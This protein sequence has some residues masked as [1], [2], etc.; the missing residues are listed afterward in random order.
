MTKVDATK[1]TFENQE[2]SIKEI[3]S[4]LGGNFFGRTI[5]RIILK[6]RKGIWVN[7]QKVA[8][9]LKSL[10]VETLDNIYQASKTNYLKTL[11]VN[12]QRFKLA[13]LQNKKVEVL[14][15]LDTDSKF[16][17]Q[18]E[19]YAK[20]IGRLAGLIDPQAKLFH[21]SEVN[22]KFI[23]HARDLLDSNFRGK[24]D[25]YLKLI[26]HLVHLSDIP[27]GTAL[28]IH[29]N[30]LVWVRKDSEEWKIIPPYSESKISVN[31]SELEFVDLDTVNLEILEEDFAVIIDGKKFSSPEHALNNEELSRA[32]EEFK[33]KL[34]ELA[35]G[36]QFQFKVDSS[37]PF[38]T[39]DEGL[40]EAE[41][42]TNF[43]SNKDERFIQEQSHDDLESVAILQAKGYLPEGEFCADWVAIDTI[44]DMTIAIVADAAKNNQNSHEGSMELTNRFR[45][46]LIS[47][48]IKL[49]KD[50]NL[51]TEDVTEALTQAIIRAEFATR[52][53]A[54][55]IASTMACTI[56]IPSEEKKYAIGFCLGDARVML[57]REDGTGKDLSPTEFFSSYSF[58]GANFGA[59]IRKIQPIFQELKRGDTILLGSDGFGDN[60]EAKTLGKSPLQALHEL[61]EARKLDDHPKLKALAE[62][63]EEWIQRA[64]SIKDWTGFTFTSSDD[65]SSLIQELHTLYSEYVLEK[66]ANT[67][68]AKDLYDHCTNSPLIQAGLFMLESE[69]NDVPKIQLIDDKYSKIGQ[70]ERQKV[71]EGF[72]RQNLERYKN[73]AEKM[74][75][76]EKMKNLFESWDLEP[77]KASD[78]LKDYW[79]E[80]ED[81][82]PQTIL[83]DVRKFKLEV[84]NHVNEHTSQFYSDIQEK[85][86]L[87]VQEIYRSNLGKYKEHATKILDLNEESEKQ[88]ELFEQWENDPKE[89]HK[90][91]LNKVGKP[92]DFSLIALTIK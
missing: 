87:E 25:E 55:V 18:P 46:I 60:M 73:F 72:C 78:W 80:F 24:P 56:I 69:K 83:E 86:D 70:E 51:T 54:K 50:G 29:D 6:A 59:G 41:A 45:Q 16:L 64:T 68:L 30:E 91:L 85:H 8:N 89:A 88:E 1:I 77:L 42:K 57:K 48:L 31:E 90:W 28:A 35:D 76:K 20:F 74:V 2:L 9:K 33:E 79:R 21:Q 43:S 61:Y 40:K 67:H 63:P 13:N 7:N 32:I 14:K 71:L 36:Q 44:G 3:E 39:L 82:I 84:E 92:D 37:K 66:M 53:E 19:M 62:N 75:E 22:A 49:Q 52:S 5:N 27:R 15:T 65:K 4:C 12:E 47:Q 26:E 23:G 38:T 11:I 10:H 34:T 17:T 58:A 81:K